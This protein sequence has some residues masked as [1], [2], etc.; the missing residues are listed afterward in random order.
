MVNKYVVKSETVFMAF[1]L[2]NE[3]LIGVAVLENNSYTF[4][5]GIEFTRLLSV[6]F[7]TNSLVTTN[8]GL[9]VSYA[10]RIADFT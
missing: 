8:L 10:R 2:K 3:F 4:S 9:G 1:T 6:R 5:V 7:N